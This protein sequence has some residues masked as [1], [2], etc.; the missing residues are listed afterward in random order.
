MAAN[1]RYDSNTDSTGQPSPK[2]DKLL[3]HLILLLLILLIADVSVKINF[4]K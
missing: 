3:A 4:K 2:S 1:R